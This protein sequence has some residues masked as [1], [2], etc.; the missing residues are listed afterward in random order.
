MES[1][2]SIENLI[3]SFTENEKEYEGIANKDIVI[4][5]GMTG[6]GKSTTYN[7]LCGSKL[8]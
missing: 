7:Y 3:K 8:E 6:V 5:L 2:E 4:L 1:I